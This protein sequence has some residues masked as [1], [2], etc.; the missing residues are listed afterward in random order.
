MILT[1]QQ[2]QAALFTIVAT[3]YLLTLALGIGGLWWQA[4]DY[5]GTAPKIIMA[6]ALYLPLLIM[7]LGVLL[8]DTRLLTWLCFVLLFYFCAYV[9]QFTDP[10]LRL[11][12]AW[13][14]GVISLLFVATMV[15][16][17]QLKV[18]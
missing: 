17:R 4:P 2:K 12:S 5:A 14:I 8:R 16:I 9:A 7:G 1:R 11:L 10:N 6:V 15:Y 18:T 13:R 3:G